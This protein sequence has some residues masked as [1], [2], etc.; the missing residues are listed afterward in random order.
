MISCNDPVNSSTVLAVRQVLNNFEN[1]RQQVSAL[2]DIRSWR[3]AEGVILFPEALCP[4]CNGV[5]KSPRIWH[6]DERGQRLIAV[7]RLDIEGK[8]QKVQSS[9]HPHVNG[10]AGGG[11]C[12]GNARSTSEAL[13]FGL[14]LGAPYWNAPRAWYKAAFDHE[15]SSSSRR[16]SR[17][18]LTASMRLKEKTVQERLAEEVI[19]ASDPWSGQT[20]LPGS[21]QPRRPRPRP[22]REPPEQPLFNG[23]MAGNTEST[24]ISADEQPTGLSLDRL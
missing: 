11:V 13:F 22:R 5:M 17:D 23:T 19:S 18:H 15:C 21:R 24:G 16:L 12:L 3:W 2:K 14:G 8:V 4:F 7:A 1:H 20:P 6:V 9:V 10:Q